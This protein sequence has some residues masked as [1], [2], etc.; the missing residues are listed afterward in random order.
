MAHSTDVLAISIRLYISSECLISAKVCRY[1]EELCFKQLL[2][3]V[4]ALIVCI[5]AGIWW[6][7]VQTEC[8]H[9]AAKFSR[10]CAH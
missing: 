10:K 3:T 2:C 9:A 4:S 5:T 7:L 6:K 1:F 8:E